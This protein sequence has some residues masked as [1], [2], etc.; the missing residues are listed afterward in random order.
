ELQLGTSP[1][2]PQSSP[3]AALDVDRITWRA[4]ETRRFGLRGVHAAGTVLF[5]ALDAS[6]PIAIP[7]ISGRLRLDPTTIAG[8]V[9]P[10]GV[11]GGVSLTVP[12]DPALDG[13]RLFAQ[14]IVGT[15]ALAFTNEVGVQLDL[16]TS[17]TIA[18]T[19]D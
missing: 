1:Y 13:A 17:T 8:V 19:F 7:G 15:T 3:A 18:E 9:G 16:T 5:A 10:I 12:S 14:A 6:A 2:D 11:P 4:G